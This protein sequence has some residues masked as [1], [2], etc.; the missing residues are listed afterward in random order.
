LL[1]ALTTLLTQSF[2]S[3]YRR[4]LA[5]RT[6][7]SLT[8]AVRDRN[9]RRSSFREDDLQLVIS[10]GISHFEVRDCKVL[11]VNLSSEKSTVFSFDYWHRQETFCRLSGECLLHA[12]INNTEEM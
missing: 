9:T 5:L 4:S 6:V 1:P 3:L 2:W 8:C 10:S 12:R 7:K 11:R